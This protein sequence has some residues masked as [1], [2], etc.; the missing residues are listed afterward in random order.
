VC[1]RRRRG[2]REDLYAWRFFVAPASHSFRFA[3]MLIS[4][5]SNKFPE[6]YVPT[7]FDNYEGIDTHVFVLHRTHSSRHCS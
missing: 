6:D 2:R 5:T 1:G 3:G 4:Y 7:V